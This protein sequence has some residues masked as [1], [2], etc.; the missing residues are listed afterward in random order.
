MIG[1]APRKSGAE[2]SSC[3]PA[4]EWVRCQV[5]LYPA[6]E[7][8]NIEGRGP[9][10]L[11][12]RRLINMPKITLDAAA[13]GIRVLDIEHGLRQIQPTGLIENELANILLL[14][15][16]ANLGLHLR[17]LNVVKIKP[18]KYMAA[19]LGIRGTELDT[20]L[21]EMEELGWARVPGT[22]DNRRVEVTVPL[23][24]PGFE[25]IGERW[26]DLGPTEI[27]QQSASPKVLT[28]TAA[29]VQPRPCM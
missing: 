17:D 6:G 23:L 8:L 11:P 22:G 21:R 13:T 25:D 12:G 29:L 19:E 28:H 26:R 9:R 24:K 18:L 20:V 27:E 4:P 15:K 10:T 1:A 2:V 3:N 14:G 16:A 7:K 5:P